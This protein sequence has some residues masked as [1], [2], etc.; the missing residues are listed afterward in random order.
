MEVYTVQ[1][2]QPSIKRK[3]GYFKVKFKTL[4][5]CRTITIHKK[6]YHFYLRS[7]TN[8]FNFLE[9]Q[10]SFLTRNGERD[11]HFYYWTNS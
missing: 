1:F 5:T 11:L 3:F 10:S 9:N 8:L 4:Y 7:Y 6:I 2:K